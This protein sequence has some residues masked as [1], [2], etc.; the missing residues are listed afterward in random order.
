MF[1]QNAIWQSAKN[2]GLLL[3]I[4]TEEK[5]IRIIVG[6]GLEAQMPD[7]LV[8]RIIEEDI[9]PLVNSGDFA[10]AIRAFYDSSIRAISTWEGSQ[11]QDSSPL[12]N[13]DKNISFWWVGLVLWFLISVFLKPKFKK[14]WKKYLIFWLLF[15][16]VILSIWLSIT[17]IVGVLAGLFFWF[18]WFMPGRGGLWW[19]WWGGGSFGWGWFSGWWGSSGGWGAGD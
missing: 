8:S 4:S 13:N 12:N 18:T 19:F 17:I 11:Y 3:L 2:N 5:K 1:N 10:W 7:L 14:K 9:R 6:Y 16:V 15:F